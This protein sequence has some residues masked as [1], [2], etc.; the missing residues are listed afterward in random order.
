[1][2]R[3][4]S[5]ILGQLGSGFKNTASGSIVPPAGKVIVAIQTLDATKFDVLTPA[6]DGLR[7]VTGGGV[8]GSTAA[9][10]GDLSF[11]ITTPDDGHGAGSLTVDNAD[12]FP[13]DM[14]IYGRWTAVSLQADQLTG[15]VICYYGY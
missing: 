11:G 13:A 7:T 5:D 4:Y 12:E 6:T 8:L 1:M 10:P 9:D 3:N 14:I 15:G 2:G